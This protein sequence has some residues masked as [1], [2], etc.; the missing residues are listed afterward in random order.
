MIRPISATRFARVFRRAARAEDGGAA[1]GFALILVPLLLI[2]FGMIEFT[3]FLMSYSQVS[4][5]VRNGTRAATINDPVAD[6]STL[7][8]GNV[9]TCTKPGG[10]VTCVGGAIG[11]AA[12]FDAVLAAMR[13]IR[14]SLQDSEVEIEYGF[15]GLGEVGTPAGIMPFVTVRIINATYTFL[16]LPALSGVPNSVPMPSFETTML[17]N[18]AATGT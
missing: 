15:S 6:V 9:M 1:V 3:G 18:G 2:T 4:Q 5:A 8:T 14:P 7:T 10:T 17:A 12:S 11:E 16:M 13:Q